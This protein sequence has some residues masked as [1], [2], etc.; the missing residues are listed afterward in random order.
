MEPAEQ[1][2][3]SAKHPVVQAVRWS[4]ARYYLYQALAFAWFVFL[5]SLWYRYVM[6]SGIPY[7]FRYL[8][9]AVIFVLRPAGWIPFEPYEKAMKRMERSRTGGTRSEEDSQEQG[10]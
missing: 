5:L 6:S 9:L 4:R 8:I 7:V 3:P 2:K 1:S 10:P